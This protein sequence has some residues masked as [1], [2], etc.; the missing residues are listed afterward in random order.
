MSLVLRVG[1][2]ALSWLRPG[3]V[4][5]APRPKRRVGLIHVRHANLEPNSHRQ[6]ED[7]DDGRDLDDA[8]NNGAVISPT[9]RRFRRQSGGSLSWALIGR[10][11]AAHSA[12]LAVYQTGS[13]SLPPQP[14]KT[15][16]ERRITPTAQSALRTARRPEAHDR[17]AQGGGGR[18]DG[19]AGA[20]IRLRPGN[21]P[22][23][24]A[25]LIAAAARDA[26]LRAAIGAGP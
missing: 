24:A 23:G 9:C 15:K 22:T 3:A 16:R 7:G 5:L 26:G 1:V 10:N 25:T 4:S 6:T 14:A 13:R 18:D 19:R 17:R 2:A 20:R 21:D 8:E 12:A 11:S